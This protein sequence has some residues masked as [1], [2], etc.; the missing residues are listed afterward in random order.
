[1]KIRWYGHASF[2]IETDGKIIYIDP[3]IIPKNPNKADIILITH[4]HYDHCDTNNIEK[5]RKLNTVIITTDGAAKKIKNGVAIVRPDDTLHINNIDIK[6]VHA[7]NI[8][9]YFHK[10]GDGVGFIIGSEGK[11]IYHSG[12]TDF[13]PE[14]KN[15]GDI[16]IALMAVGGKYTMN[17]R[18]AADAVKVI[19]PDIAIPMHWGNVVGS[20]EDAKIFK[21][22]VERETNTKVLILDGEELDIS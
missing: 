16:N 6:A 4:E 7:Y 10:K 20:R 5:L 3:Y 21:E 13:I 11:R 18:E 1:L 2:M 8:N 22:I 17:A 19:R 15:L 12:D 14:M 9:K